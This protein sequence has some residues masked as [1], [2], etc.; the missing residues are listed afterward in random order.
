MGLKGAE[1]YAKNIKE[2][3]VKTKLLFMLRGARQRAREENVP[4]DLD[5]A[6]ATEQFAN[7]THCEIIGIKLNW[8]VTGTGIAAPNSP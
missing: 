2:Q 4:F 6:W 5:E 8:S 3:P 7:V 1:R